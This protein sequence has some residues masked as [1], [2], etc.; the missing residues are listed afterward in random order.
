MVVEFL[1][2]RVDPV[3]VERWLEAEAKAWTSALRRRPGFVRKEL[4]RSA[5]DP[6]EVHAVIWWQSEEAW[7]SMSRSEVAA[8]D[9]QMGSLL[10]TP[11]ERTFQVLRR[12]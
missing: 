12:D 2:F 10:R 11:V 9:Q 6:G 3:D 5:A 4:W 1:T 7:K 8:V